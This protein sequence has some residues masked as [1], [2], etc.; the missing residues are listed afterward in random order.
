M[1]NLWFQVMSVNDDNVWNGGPEPTNLTEGTTS[2][3][4][5]CLKR[6]KEQGDA[7]KLIDGLTSEEVSA[8]QLYERSVHLAKC[9]KSL[10]H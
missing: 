5:L 1:P 6:L 3:G 2:L 4:A 7:I 10:W 8:K 9:L